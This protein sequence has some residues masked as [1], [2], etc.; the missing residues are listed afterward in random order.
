MKIEEKSES[1][2]VEM[3]NAAQSSGKEKN[4]W[5]YSTFFLAFVLVAG[6]FYILGQNSGSVGEV[7]NNPAQPTVP[8]APVKVDSDDDAFKGNS[9]SPVT[10]IEFSDYECPFCQRFY[11][12]TLPQIEQNYI[13][14]GK[15]KLVYRDFPLSIHPQAQKAAEAAEC[16]GEQNKY[17][18]MHN[19]LFEKGVSG[20]VTS[21]KQ[22]AKDLGLNSAKFD[23]CLDSSKM[24]SEVQKDMQDGQ[25]YGVRGT[26]AFFVNGQLISGAQP[27][28]NFQQAI[29][30]ALEN[31]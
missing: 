20:G 6:L 19:L 2:P 3:A 27:Y 4:Y 18:E 30:A 21:F 26:P 5:K 16:A 7:I 17:W 15:V 22:Y 28:T 24:A 9:N 25:S 23:D 8:S 13:K 10:I 11:Q 29:E 1:T 12:Q 14:T 31:K